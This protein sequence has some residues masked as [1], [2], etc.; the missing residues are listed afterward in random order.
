MRCLILTF[1]FFLSSCGKLE[2]RF[3]HPITHSRIESLSLETVSNLTYYDQ[4]PLDLEKLIRLSLRQRY[5]VTIDKN[6]QQL[7]LRLTFINF[8]RG[9]L[10]LAGETAQGRSLSALAKLE[11]ID[12]QYGVIATSQLSESETYTDRSPQDFEAA[13]NTL[14][15]RLADQLV[16]DLIEP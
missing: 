11:L 10:P 12:D 9:Q 3:Y 8:K 16:M 14:F 1:L 4:E 7:K 5:F 6:R 15:K 2:M 13:R